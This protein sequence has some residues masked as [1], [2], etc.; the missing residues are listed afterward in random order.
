MPHVMTVLGPVDPS[1]LGYTLPHEHTQCTLWHIGNRWDYWELTADE[2]VIL[3]EL[4]L[5]K[6]AGGT[7]LVDVTLPGIGRD[8]A[9][10]TRIAGQSGLHIVM[11]GGWYRTSYY[12]VEAMIE[13]RSVDGLA[14][15]LVHDATVGVGETGVRIGI[16]GEIGTDKPWMTP[17]EERVHR[18]VARASRR[19][20]LAITTHAV[21]S[22]VGQWQLTV[23]EEEGVDPGRVVIGHADSYPVLDHY[24]S[25]IHRGASLEF[26]FLG[27]SFTPM[28][29]H[30]EGKVIDLL[31][32]L[33]HRGHGDRILL[34][35]DVC[36][37]SQLRHFE[38]NGYTYLTEHFL[39]KLRE[40]GVSEDEIT[41]L[42]VANPRRVLTI[43]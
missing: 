43:G 38:G 25:L 23:F 24:L 39:P 12:P 29:R 42:V 30:G 31:L 41:Q 19:T 32:E 4:R 22:D 8:P 37:N 7:C 1:A 40:R 33:L 3:E 17:I 21:M 16:L 15:E 11:G 35:H 34:S 9:W 10:L 6:E 14:E 13:R 20:G 5:F 18:A 27:M 2:P 26:D 36:H 28:E